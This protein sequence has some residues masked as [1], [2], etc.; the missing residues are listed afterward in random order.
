[1]FARGH[2][3]RGVDTG[4]LPE[5]LGDAAFVF[6]VSERCTPTSAAIP[7]P[8][9]VAPWV[10]TIER[11]WDDPEFESRHRAVARAEAFRWE[12]GRPGSQYEELFTA[13]SNGG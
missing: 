12:S 6:T 13:R 1:L 8:H 4:A 11:L 9:Q 7:T 10:A 3:I 5:T 2:L